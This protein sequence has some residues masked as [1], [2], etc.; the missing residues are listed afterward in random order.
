MAQVTD[1]V[2]Q[3][4]ILVRSPSGEAILGQWPENV[5]ITLGALIIFPAGDEIGDLLPCRAEARIG[6]EQYAILILGPPAL[7]KGWIQRMEPPFATVL[8]SQ[9]ASLH[10]TWEWLCEARRR[11]DLLDTQIGSPWQC[12]L[13]CLGQ[14]QSISPQILWRGHTAQRGS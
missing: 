1:T 8:G 12:G 13:G 6:L 14:S 2:A 7:S 3:D 11:I 10:A 4:A 9:S 5:N